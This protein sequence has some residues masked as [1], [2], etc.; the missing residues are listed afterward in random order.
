MP[1][2]FIELLAAQRSFQQRLGND[3]PKDFVTF[4]NVQMSLEHNTYQ[5][6]EFQEFLEADQED[7]KEEL[8]DYLLFMINKYLFLGVELSRPLKKNHLLIDFSKTT[9]KNTLWD[10]L[11]DFSIASSSNESNIEQ[12]E[13]IT[14]I[15]KHAQFKPWKVR[16]EETCINQE[17]ATLSFYKA[18]EHFRKLSKA[19]YSSYTELLK[20]LKHKLDV[21]IQRQNNHY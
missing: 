12:D 16:K 7:K 6:V 10:D 4:T 21:N 15:R 20:H 19:T 5:I 11:I 8:I 2:E 3:L 1:N 14:L 13:Y 18:L 17:E 9:L